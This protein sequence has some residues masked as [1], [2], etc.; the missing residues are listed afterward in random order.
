MKMKCGNITCI[1]AVYVN[2]ILLI[3]NEFEI[4]QTAS[5]I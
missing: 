3:G 4:N 2:D 1:L 5:L